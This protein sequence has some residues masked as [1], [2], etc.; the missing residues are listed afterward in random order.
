MPALIPYA[1]SD[2]TTLTTALLAPGS[3]VTVVPGSIVLKESGSAAV[4]LYDGSLIPLGIGSGLLLTSGTT[5]GTANTVG[6]FGQDNSGASGF[7]NGDP[8]IDA[9]VNSVFQTQSYDATT[10]SFDFT[11]ADP[12][13]TSV[14]FDVVFGSD[15]FPE[16]VDQFVD[17]AIVMVNGVNYALF[18]HD[19]AHPLSVV[20]GNLAAGYFQDNAGNVLPIEYDGVSHVLKIVAPIVPGA[21]NHIKI[22]IADT[23]DHIYDS[24]IFLANLSAGT[25]PGSGVVITPPTTGTD[26]KDDLTGSVKDEYFDLKGGDDTVYAGGGDDIVVAGSGNDTVFGGSG[27]DQMKGDSG[28]DSLDGGAD[29]DTVIYAGTST[30]YTIATAASGFTIADTK[31]GPTS[32]GSDTL[33]NVEYAKFSDGLFSIGA[34][35][36]LIPVTDPGIPPANTPGSV[37]ING[38]AS[39]GKILTAA[40]SDP[41]GISGPISY[42][43]QVSGDGGGSWTNVGTDANTYTVVTS[44]TGNTIQ[45]IAS[46]TDN[47]AQP[48][49]PVSAAKPIQPVGEGDLI[50]TLMQL[51]AP[52]GA[53]TIN[54]LT[55]LVKDAI[56]FGLSPN[57]A[58]FAIKTVLGIP[59]SVN[60][61]SYDAYA[62]LKTQPSNPTALAV[63][64]IATQIAILTSLSDDDKATNLTLKILDAA[65]LNKTL[66][67][68]NAHDLA[69]ILAIDITGITDPKNYPEP[70]RE[71]FDRNDNIAQAG[72]VSGIEAE[73]QDFLTIQDGVASTSIADLSIHINQNPNGIPTTILTDGIAD[74]PYTVDVGALLQGFTDPESDTLSVVGLTADNGDVTDN[75]TTFT[76]TPNL[77]Y[78][79]PVDLA[80]TVIDGQ[81]GSAS[82]SQLFAVIPC[83]AAGT[84][85]ETERGQVVVECLSVGD[86][87]VTADG[88]A[89]PIVWIGSRTVNCKAHPRP[90]TVWPVRV[91]AGAV[92]DAEPRKDLLLSPDHAVFADGVLIPIKYLTNGTTIAQVPVDEVTYY[93]VELTQHDLLLAEGLVV[94]SYLDTG[95]RTNFS[96]A[97][98]VMR[99]YPDF[100]T[101]TANVAAL[102]ES[103]ACAPLVITGPMLVAARL[104]LEERARKIGVKR[105]K[106]GRRR[107]ADG[108][109]RPRARITAPVGTLVAN[110]VMVG[111]GP[112]STTSL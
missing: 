102:W 13:A 64:K 89:E 32:E 49:T 48:E 6:W 80:Y 1:G 96:N 19:P 26:G 34:G 53:S 110:P 17:S 45:V 111:A 105:R 40:V 107:G 50:V 27:A 56:G 36:A 52:I 100:S 101:H 62:V 86:R 12:T 76:I 66:R 33:T 61:Q 83:F 84:H 25:I 20:S 109:V 112:P 28:D 15:E 7:A 75:G 65:S 55:T 69:N 54:P 11:V 21:V 2:T 35:G 90:E 22:G 5:P 87:V 37:V 78:T 23:G 46:Y 81:G 24:G 60:L 70:L 57:N 10:L 71:I 42:Q 88:R 43:W 92:A 58:I 9:V 108:G 94:E 95:D 47:G 106:V 8:N 4:N 59:A 68:N 99:L 67:L 63:E 74:T 44:D 77:G 104:K 30:S 93:H 85:I 97:G 51:D 82:A 29:L 31:S 41:D 39:T 16:W 73:W 14:S 18:N 79:G 91:Q 3:G 103:L 72:N 38:I 98:Q